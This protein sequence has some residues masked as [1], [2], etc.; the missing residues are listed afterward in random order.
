VP[1]WVEPDSAAWAAFDR[2]YAARWHARPDW[3]AASGYDALRLVAAALRRSGL[4][5]VRRRD[6]VRELAPYEGASGVVRW[7]GRG[8]N[9]PPLRVEAWRDGRLR[10]LP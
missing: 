7:D 9:E 5:R 3:A 2:D 8:R 1:S 4:N 10:P 6:A